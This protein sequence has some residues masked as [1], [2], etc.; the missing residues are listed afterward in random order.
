[1]QYLLYCVIIIDIKYLRKCL[2]PIKTQ[3]VEILPELK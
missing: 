3:H 2:A 1:M